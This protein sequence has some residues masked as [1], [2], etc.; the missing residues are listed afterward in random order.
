MR[1]NGHNPEQSQDLTQGFFADLIE[2][3]DFAK[4][5]KRGRFRSYLLA[6]LRNFLM[7]EKAKANALKRGGDQEPLS[8]DWLALEGRYLI[9]VSDPR[10]N[11]EKVYE[12][13]WTLTLLERV[14]ATLREQYRERELEPLFEAL[15]PHLT[16][17]SE[18]MTHA[19][20]GQLLKMEEGAVKVAL[21]RMRKR[22]GEALRNEVADTV[23]ELKNVDDELRYLMSTL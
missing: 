6:A 19:E 12:R 16:G 2:R 7:N 21:H 8:L 13:Q 10:L 9:E 20:V 18:A 4:I 11:A 23:G 17:L 15:S 14:L 5:Q 1:R 3:G 22:Y